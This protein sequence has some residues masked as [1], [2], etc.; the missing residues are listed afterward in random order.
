[1]ACWRLS[2]HECMDIFVGKAVMDE[3]VRRNADLDAL[4]ACLTGADVR[5]AA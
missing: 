1:M 5:N 4:Q 3:R 2:V